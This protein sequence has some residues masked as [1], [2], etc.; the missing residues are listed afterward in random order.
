MF[1]PMDF[2]VG[3]SDGYPESNSGLRK[4]LGTIPWEVYLLRCESCGWEIIA[5]AHLCSNCN[6]VVE[7][8]QSPGS[9]FGLLSTIFGGGSPTP[10]D[11]RL[12]P[13]R[14]QAEGIP[15]GLLLNNAGVS[16]CL[17]KSM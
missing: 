13:A 6:T 16:C 7:Q 8:P 11:S 3:Y 15:S 10:K 14:T 12:A 17:I 5:H 2:R 4:T 9:L 1:S